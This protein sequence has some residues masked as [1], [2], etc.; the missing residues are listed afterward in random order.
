[1][2]ECFH[3]FMLQQRFLRLNFL[4]FVMT[5][6]VFLLFISTVFLGFRHKNTFGSSKVMIISWLKIPALLTT[7]TD[8]NCT[9]VSLKEMFKCMIVKCKEKPVSY[10]LCHYWLIF[11][12]LYRELKYSLPLLYSL[13]KV[14]SYLPLHLDIQLLLKSV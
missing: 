9:K 1:M 11:H 5:A 4:Y 10:Q 12:K 14:A 7:D 2:A 3:F 13:M 8:G 6:Q